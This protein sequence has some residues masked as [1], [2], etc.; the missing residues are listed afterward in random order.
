MNN[1]VIRNIVK[2]IIQP[3]SLLQNARHIRSCL[4]IAGPDLASHSIIFRELSESLRS[5]CNSVLV[6]V[7]ANESP[8]L[9]VVFKHIV[10]GI[11]NC[12]T[13]DDD[14]EHVSLKSRGRKML[15]YDL[16]II[17][18]WLKGRNIEKVVVALEDSEAF[19][20]TLIAD[21]VEILRH[22]DHA[23]SLLLN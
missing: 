13:T 20:N 4:I 1:I 11:T 5:N 16:Q 2:Y 19:D 8:N 6:A 3:S 18:D 17:Q 7:R 22:V 10:A 23:L 12:Q 14:D 15:S 9:K 21:I